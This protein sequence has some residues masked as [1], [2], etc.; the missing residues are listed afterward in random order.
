MGKYNIYRRKDG[1]FEG[2]V[3]CKEVGKRSYRSFY[4]SSVD[5]VK[6]KI[7]AFL[8]PVTDSEI[9]V[10]EILV[11]WL[12]S[13]THRIK[14]STASNYQMKIQKHIIPFFISVRYNEI[15]SSQVYS[16]VN[17]KKSEGLSLRYIS[18]MIV[19]LKSAFRHAAVTRCVLNPLDGFRIQ[20]PDHTEIRILDSKQQKQL[21]ARFSNRATPTDLGVALSL[22]TGLRIGEVCAMK[23]SDIDLDK[24]LLTVSRTIQRIQDFNGAA[25]TKLVITEPK[26]AHSKR[27]IPIPDGIISLLKRFKGSH[28]SFILS[29]SDK[30]VE[31]RTMQNRFARLLKNE[32][33][34]SVHYHSLR[35]AFATRA[36]AVG[37]DVKTLSEILGHCSV[38]L[39]LNLYVHSSLER[40][41]ACMELMTVDQ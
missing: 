26:S 40:K 1:R 34:P 14:A 9:T 12:Q 5:E 6:C 35:H 38:E 30:P 29:G 11:D 41:R 31:P 16:F 7:N 39:T 22:Y 13:I 24:R 18:D 25:K 2:R 28:D 19:I 23:W 3:Y 20:K 8:P 10:K 17:S 21:T 36:I 4:G 15:S 32:N 27:T 37:F 33:L